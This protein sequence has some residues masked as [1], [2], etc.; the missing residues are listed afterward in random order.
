MIAD[1][2]ICGF[3]RLGTMFGTEAMG[4]KPDLITIAKGVTSAYVPLSGCMVSEKV[5]RTLVEGGSRFGA[6]GHGYTYTAH[7]LAAAAALANLRIIEE[8]SLV[9]AAAE[10]GSV[11]HARLQEAFAD[12]P[13]VGEIRG[14]GLIGAIEFV[15]KRDPATKFDAALKV[16]PRIVKAARDHGVISR[17][18]P[19]SDSM[20]FSPPLVITPEEIDLMVTRVR[21]AV[22]AVMDELVR[23]GS[24][25][26]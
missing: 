23:D 16:G 11:M 19:L 22:D 17:A 5:W 6:F 13:L 20:S 2:V 18:L 24:W 26:G 4:M 15:A 14:F 10:N 9:E 7:P 25:K 3:G 12:H 1:E 21:E 8:E